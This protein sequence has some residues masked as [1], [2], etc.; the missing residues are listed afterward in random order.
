MFSYTE[1]T[2][3]NPSLAMEL[4]IAADLMFDTVLETDAPFTLENRLDTATTMLETLITNQP[5]PQEMLSTA[6][7]LSARLFAVVTTMYETQTRAEAMTIL[8]EVTLL[9]TWHQD[10]ATYEKSLAVLLTLVA[11][12][13]IVDQEA[14]FAVV[15]FALALSAM[16]SYTNELPHAGDALRNALNG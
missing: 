15:P 13:P 4:A 7:A 11:D 1:A 3:V 14:L 5:L 8:S 2:H 12:E 9:H 16:I 6:L 10:E